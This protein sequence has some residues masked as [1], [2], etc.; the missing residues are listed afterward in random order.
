[1][2][3]FLFSQRTGLQRAH[4]IRNESME[5]CFVF[6]GIESGLVPEMQMT[7]YHINGPR[8]EAGLL[9]IVCVFKWRDEITEGACLCEKIQRLLHRA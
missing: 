4:Q 1:M 9:K 6:Q 2:R 5:C 7:E 8:L 3:C